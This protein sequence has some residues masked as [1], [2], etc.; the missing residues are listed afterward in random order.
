MIYL[1]KTIV[2]YQ[3]YKIPVIEPTTAESNGAPSVK[4][5]EEMW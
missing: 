1:S 3:F 2:V 5:I 4:E